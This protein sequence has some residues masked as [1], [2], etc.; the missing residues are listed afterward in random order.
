MKYRDPRDHRDYDSTDNGEALVA[1]I[2]V[3]AA[4]YLAAAVI[5]GWIA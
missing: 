2:I 1:W 3:L 4:A 5:L